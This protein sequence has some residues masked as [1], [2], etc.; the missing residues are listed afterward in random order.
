MNNWNL[1]KKQNTIDISS[2]NEK[3]LGT[4]LTKYAN[5]PYEGN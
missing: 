4:N 3:Y 5:D 2:K 1:N